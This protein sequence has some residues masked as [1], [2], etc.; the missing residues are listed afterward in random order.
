MFVHFTIYN[1]KHIPP[2]TIKYV[3]ENS[4]FLFQNGNEM[5]FH[6]FA[7]FGYLALEMFWKSFGIVFK[8][9]FMSLGYML[10]DIILDIK[11]LG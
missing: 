10:L 3:I 7:K 11:N 9:I 6:D 4:V 1:G 2:K 8:G 5:E